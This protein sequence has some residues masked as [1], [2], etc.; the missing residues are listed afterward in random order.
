MYFLGQVQSRIGH[1]GYT[2]VFFLNADNYESIILFAF[3]FL[4]LS[5]LFKGLVYYSFGM[6]LKLLICE[7]HGFFVLQGVKIPHASN[8]APVTGTAITLIFAVLNITS[9]HFLVDYVQY[10]QS[11]SMHLKYPKSLSFALLQDNLKIRLQNKR[12]RRRPK[13]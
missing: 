7:I 2:P 8:G 3:T 13:H 12:R 5:Y 1:V 10:P 9:T 4:Q 6:S 11:S